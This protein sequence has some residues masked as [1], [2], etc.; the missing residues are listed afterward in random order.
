MGLIRGN[1]IA[2]ESS[3]EMFFTVPL[4]EREPYIY[5][6]RVEPDVNGVLMLKIADSCDLFVVRMPRRLARTR[7][8]HA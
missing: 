5:E 6:R 1:L 8:V 2:S 4:T 3:K 7:I